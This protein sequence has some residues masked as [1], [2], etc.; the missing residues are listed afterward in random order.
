MEKL[1]LVEYHKKQRLERFYEI[2]NKFGKEIS[3]MIEDGKTIGEIIKYTGYPYKNI[4]YF[5]E[6]EN[7]YDKTKEN[8]KTRKPLLAVENGKKSA[9]TLK[10]VELKPLTNEIKQWFI[11]QSKNGK[12]KYEIRNELWEKF[13]YG[14]K[15]YYQLCEEL[16]TPMSRPNTGKYNPMYGRT[17]SKKAGIGVKGWVYIDG[18]KLFFRSSLELKVYLYLENNK[19]SFLQ[20]SHRISYSNNGIEKTYCPDIVIGDTIYEIKPDALTKTELVIKK[21]TALK[22]Y[23]KKYNLNCDFI[24]ENTFSLEKL[25]QEEIDLLID[26]KKLIIDE[27]NYNKLM[28]YL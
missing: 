7:L 13:G 26:N 2:K 22:N 14:E 17:P 15:K 4:R 28:R 25:T 12:F 1:K 6:T 20:S 8:W 16:G 27:K 23:C 10:G 11:E 19:I 21:F 3:K 9:H 18:N 24:T 5:L